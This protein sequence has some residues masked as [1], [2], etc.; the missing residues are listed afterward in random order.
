[1]ISTELQTHSVPGP[2]RELN[3]AIP[4][5]VLEFMKNI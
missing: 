1:M 3:S 2:L 4:E 5:T